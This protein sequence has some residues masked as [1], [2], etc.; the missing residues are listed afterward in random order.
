MKSSSEN[1]NPAESPR[2]STLVSEA[3][4][5]ANRR[6]AR[7]EAKEAVEGLRK[8]HA[9]KAARKKPHQAA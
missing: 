9:E 8:L 3:T 6:W 4:R 7:L 1:T 5:E 2:K